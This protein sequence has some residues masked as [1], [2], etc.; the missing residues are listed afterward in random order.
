MPFTR[1]SLRAA[2]AISLGSAVAV[3]RRDRRRSFVRRPA[4]AAIPAFPRLC[5]SRPSTAIPTTAS[6]RPTP[7]T[8]IA[9]PAT[10]QYAT[11]AVQMVEDQV[12][13]AEAAIANGDAPGCR[14]R[15]VSLRRRHDSAI[16][17]SPTTGA[18]TFV[19]SSQRT[20]WS[21]YAEQALYNVW[22]PA[23]GA[24]GRPSGAVVR[25]GDRRS[26]QQLFLQLPRSDDV[27]GARRA[28]ASTC[29]WISSI[30]SSSR[31]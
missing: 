9:S 19:T 23:A 2:C 17:R 15:F 1:A 18:A 8:C 10:A 20:R 11:L 12:S 22:N 26:G 27:L 14:G 28:T 24:M 31:S 3:R 5:R 25:L 6:R 13:E 16:S 30:P 4:I 21:A 29:G 7:R